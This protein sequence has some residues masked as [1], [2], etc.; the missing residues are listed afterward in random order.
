MALREHLIDGGRWFLGLSP[1]EVAFNRPSSG[2]L[3]ITAI[4]PAY[5][6]EVSIAS[7]IRSL[8]AQTYRL[9]EIIVVDDCSTDRTG[10][11]AR[12]LGAAVYRTPKNRGTKAQAQNLALAFVKTDLFVTVDADTIVAPDAVEKTIRYFNDPKTLI[13]SG[14][15]VPQKIQTLWERGRFIEYLYGLTIIK[16]AQNHNR[17]VLVAS[18]CFS[19]FRTK[20]TLEEFGHFNERTMAEDLDLTWEATGKGYHV[21]FAPE[22]KCYPVDPPTFGIYVKQLSRWYRGFLQNIAVR[23]FYKFGSWR[24]QLLIYVYVVWFLIGPMMLPVMLL[25]AGYGVVSAIGW[26]MALQMITMG[27]PALWRA[28]RLGMFS[29]A[30]ASFPAPLVTQ[31]VSFGVYLYSI[32]KEWILRDKLHSWDKGH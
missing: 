23:K 32:W 1:K 21:Y 2:R 18:G 29:T 25:W 20:E 7:T 30:P 10:D 5:N 24:L 9:D 26:M 27:V 3:S 11:I 17:M 6:E 15:V 19:V 12:S 22:A 16:P 4:I 14:F 8:Q 13:V 31:Y 28:Y